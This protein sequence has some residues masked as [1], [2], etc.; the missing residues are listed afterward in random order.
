MDL[1]SK[2]LLEMLRIIRIAAKLQL[3]GFKLLRK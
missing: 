3:S 2:E 1:K